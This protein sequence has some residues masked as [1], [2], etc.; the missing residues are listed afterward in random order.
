MNG[1]IG[2][3]AIA[4]ANLNNPAKVEDSLEKTSV[5]ADQMCIRDRE[6]TQLRRRRR[7]DHGMG[8][9]FHCSAE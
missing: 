9:Q 5:A 8:R 6:D 1:I 7:A 3:T 2:M 4:K